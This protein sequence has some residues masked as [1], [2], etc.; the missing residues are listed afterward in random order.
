[1]KKHVISI[2]KHFLIIK[3]KSFFQITSKITLNSYLYIL[4][5][6]CSADLLSLAHFPL[7]FD[8]GR[9]EVFCHNL[10]LCYRGFDAHWQH[11]GHPIVHQVS[12]H[13]PAQLCVWIVFWMAHNSHPRVRAA[14]P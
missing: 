5:T 10:E 3:M 2:D 14:I 13:S 9:I 8:L 1:M 4:L 12:F 11:T 7:Q 6:F